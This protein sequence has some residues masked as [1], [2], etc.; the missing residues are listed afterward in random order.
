[1]SLQQ[2]HGHSYE[3]LMN[4]GTCMKLVQYNEIFMWKQGI[5]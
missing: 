5:F 2:D 3:S 4:K 1:M